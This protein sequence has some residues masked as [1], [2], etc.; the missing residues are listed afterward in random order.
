M[1]VLGVKDY[2]DPSPCVRAAFLVPSLH[3]GGAERW[4]LDL[5]RFCDPSRIIW[6]GAVIVHPRWV[7]S[8]MLWALSSRMPVFHNNV[9]WDRGKQRRSSLDTAVHDLLA[10]ADVILTWEVNEVARGLLDRIG[11]PVVNVAHRDDEESLTQNLAESDHLVAVWSSCTGAFNKDNVKR[12]AVILNGIDLNRC[13]P[14]RD[15]SMMRRE[16]GV[17]EAKLLVGYLGRIDSQK[18]CIAIARAV[19]GLG[20]GAFGVIVGSRSSRAPEVESPVQ[21]MVGNRVRLCP[22]VEDVGSALA[23]IDVFMLPSFTEVLSLS[24]L[25]AWAAEVPVVATRVGAVPDLEAEHGPLVVPME[26]TWGAGAIATAIQ[27]ALSNDR[28]LAVMRKRAAD[29][30]RERFNVLR[31]ADAWTDYLV[32]TFGEK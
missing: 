6:T 26:P 31:M 22:P 5:A 29:L 2:S 1:R 32:T 7:D 4:T 8:R 24:L 12:V 14:L 3:Y 23:A 16:W 19:R 10:V 17:E 20:E 30:V 15:R 27:Y 9:V 25:E 21:E 28:E 18:N 13:Y 11:L